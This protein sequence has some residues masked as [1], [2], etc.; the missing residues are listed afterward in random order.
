MKDKRKDPNQLLKDIA[1]K[2]TNA[3]YLN[4]VETRPVS[5]APHTLRNPHHLV[6]H[7]WINVKGKY[8]FKDYLKDL[9]GHCAIVRDHLQA[10]HANRGKYMILKGLQTRILHRNYGLCHFYKTQKLKTNVNF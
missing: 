7:T 2:G 1:E 9:S 5:V 8:G 4:Q 10:L 3:I 6:L